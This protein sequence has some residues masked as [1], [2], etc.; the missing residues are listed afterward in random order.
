MASSLKFL[1]GL[2]YNNREKLSLLL[3]VVVVVIVV[4][5]AAA[6]TTM[7]TIMT[8]YEYIQPLRHEQNVA[9]ANFSVKYSWF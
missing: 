6:T 9:Q 5:E 4:V 8:Y 2:L 3:L 1:L 7:I